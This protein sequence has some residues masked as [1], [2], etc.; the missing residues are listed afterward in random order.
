LVAFPEGI[1]G[2]TVFEV[3]LVVTDE[4]EVVVMTTTGLELGA[5]LGS[6][7]VVV[8]D[9]TDSGTESVVV[10]SVGSL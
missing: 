2:T 10:V 3:T 6:A 7:T 9:A 5:P 4:K 8:V 1:E